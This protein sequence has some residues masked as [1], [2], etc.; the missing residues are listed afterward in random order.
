MKTVL[1]YQEENQRM[2]VLPVLLALASTVYAKTICDNE[3]VKLDI[4]PEESFIAGF[5]EN[6]AQRA[7]R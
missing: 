1:M 4:W 3:H 2:A 7:W 6:G 5:N